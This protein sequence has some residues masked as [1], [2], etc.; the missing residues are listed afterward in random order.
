MAVQNIT[1]EVLQAII[2]KS[3]ATLPDRTSES[4]LTADTIRGRLY[5]AITDP[6]NSIY[7]EI[8]RIVGEVNEI[9]EEL[10][11]N[12]VELRRNG[13]YVQ[14]RYI[15]GAEWKNLYQ[16]N[17]YVGELDEVETSIDYE[18]VDN[19]D[20][21]Y[22]EA[23]TAVGITIPDTVAHGFYAGLNWIAD[24]EPSAVIFTNDS[25]YELKIIKFGLGISN[26]T[27]TG[28]KIINM[29]FFCDGL[30]VYCYINEVT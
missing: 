28:G 3:A 12:L 11:E 7:S 22:S 4:G 30:Y 16:I 14:W 21:S 10:G 25:S 19:V 2:R 29:I 1:N 18:L 24:T 9:L 26:Y 5:K 17:S 15:G 6:T 13:D 23:M 20:Q 27:P 8:N